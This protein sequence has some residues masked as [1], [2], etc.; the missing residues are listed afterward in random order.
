MLIEVHMLQ[1]YAPSNLNRDDTGAPKDAIFGN[2]LRA[3]ISSQAMKRAI[4]KSAVFAD[5]FGGTGLLANR[6]RR[7]PAQLRI[8]LERAGLEATAIDAIVTRSQEIGRESGRQITA[9]TE[10]G[11]PETAQ[12]IFLGEE[13]IDRLAERLAGLY[14]EVGEAEFKKLKVEEITKRLGASIA[15]SVDIAMF[16]RMT[17]SAAF[18]NV[19]AAVQVAHAISTHRIDPEFDYYTAVDDISGESGAGFIGDTAFNSAT[20]YKYASIHWEGLV[21]NLGGDSEVAAKAVAAFV[22]AWATTSPT[23]KQNSFAAHNLPDLVLVEVRERNLP[24][25]YANAFVKPVWGRGSESLLDASV[26]ALAVY[27]NKLD[28]VY[29]LSAQS[30]RGWIGTGDWDRLAG[31]HL[32]SLRELVGWLPSGRATVA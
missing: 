8:R 29:N 26:D 16:G 27:L 28:E 31:T 20:Y 25:S 24:V 22:E 18:E 6:T 7:L 23:G 17:T 13:E 30:R 15:R 10:N 19:D 32:G 1:N 2:A 14:Q 5:V 3:R 9:S 12:L 21:E 11:D 4:R